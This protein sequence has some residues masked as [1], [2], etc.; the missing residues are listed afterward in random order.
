MIW[1]QFMNATAE[2]SARTVI[3][4]AFERHDKALVATSVASRR[5]D[6][7]I[8]VPPGSAAHEVAVASVEFEYPCFFWPPWWTKTEF[9][10][11]GERDD[12][13]L[14]TVAFAVDMPLELRRQGSYP[15]AHSILIWLLSKQPLVDHTLSPHLHPRTHRFGALVVSKRA[16]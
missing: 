14:F 15:V 11:I 13:N 2:A 16:E 12:K 10:A 8:P 6:S 5:H 9:S 7:M 3:F 1:P 4:L